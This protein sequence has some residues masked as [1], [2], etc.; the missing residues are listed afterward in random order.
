MCIRDRQRVLHGFKF[1]AGRFVLLQARRVGII[2]R[3]V[4][5]ERGAVLR[6][7][8]RP[9]RGVAV[10]L[11]L[12][13]VILGLAG[14]VRCLGLVELR[15]AFLQRLPPRGDGAAELALAVVILRPARV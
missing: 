9:R 6:P 12:A 4:G 13:G 7:A 14:L 8:V 10:V 3:I 5:V 11:R 2:V 1:G 15:T